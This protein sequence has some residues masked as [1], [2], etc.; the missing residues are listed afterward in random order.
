M[1]K[2]LLD[3]STV[4]LDDILSSSKVYYV[5]PFQRDYS[6]SEEHWEDLWED[7]KSL[8]ENEESYHYMG[9]IVLQR[10]ADKESNII[11]GQ[12][13]FT[14]FTIII[15]SIINRIEELAKNDNEKEQ[16]EER[17]EILRRNYLGDK[18]PTTLKYTSKLFLNR[19][20]D[21]YF[22]D[23]LLQLRDANNVSSLSGSN[24]KLN[25]AFKYFSKKIN[26][27]EAYRNNGSALASLITELVSRR[28]L[29]I[30]INVEDELSAYI[31]FET[32]NARGVELTSTDL[33][34][35]YL[36][37]LIGDDREI[38]LL[39]RK[40]KRI[41][42]TVGSDKFPDFV[43]YYINSKRPLVRSERLFKNIKDEISS[44]PQAIELLEELEGNA[45]VFSALKNHNSDIW[46][47]RQQVKPYIHA[48]SLFNIKQI[49][50]MLLA[51]YSMMTG[52]EFTK[53]VKL[54]V[55]I[56]FRYSVICRKN[57]NEL[58]KAYN[59][60]AIRITNGE[61]TLARELHDELRG[62]YVSDEEFE[63]DFS[64]KIINNNKRKKLVRY[65]LFK[66]E[67]DC[68]D[69]I[70]RDFL[71]DNGTIEHILPENPTSEWNDSFPADAQE[72]YIYR[73]GNYTL[74]EANIN[75]DIGNGIFQ[76]KSI[77]YIESRY[78]MTKS[79]DGGNWTIERLTDRQRHFAR[80]ACH[81][82]RS[83]YA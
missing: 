7:I 47:E 6:W 46:K 14:T 39:Q 72:Q 20:N 24:K 59:S 19:N 50:P 63:Q 67:E 81:I 8:I 79:I 80:R 58:E 54:S 45:E 51:A 16:N 55:A 82:W 34:K 18:H 23:Y 1:A 61:V 40:W 48:L 31:V 38:E 25:K 2:N 32:L 9:S 53:V 37:S 22:Q 43:R 28:M 10:K 64:T 42:D 49:T 69:G 4:T 56:S 41:S 71:A 26:E 30:Q 66:L 70:A 15:L 68:P 33:L 65:I 57:P 27:L 77:K 29:F 5:P 13:R 75:R 83:D 73:L 62:I 44:A 35:N 12:Q 78:E 52:A 17:V 21:E 76:D 11:D 60:A 36:F 3:T 74:L